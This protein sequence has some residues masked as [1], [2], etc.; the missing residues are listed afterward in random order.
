MKLAVGIFLFLLFQPRE[1]SAQKTLPHPAGKA[2]VFHVELGYSYANV[3]IPGLTRVGLNGLDWGATIDVS[4]RFG[5]DFAGSYASGPSV[6]VP[7][8]PS[9]L[10]TYAGGVVAYPLETKHISV[11][12]RALYGGAKQDGANVSS[13]HDFLTG[14]VNQAAWIAGGALDY[15]ID[16]HWSIRFSGDYIN[17]S[18]FGPQA[19]IERQ[20][21]FRTGVGIVYTFGRRHR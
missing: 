14:F 11:R 10:F 17:S 13:N 2:A 19:N 4:R 21:N 18:F 5:L 8:N 12:V 16:Q 7:N 6:A 20:N 3:S 15:K 1:A 9:Q